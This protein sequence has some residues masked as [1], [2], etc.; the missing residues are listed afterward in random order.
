MGRRRAS[1]M[2][3]ELRQSAQKRKSAKMGKK[4]ENRE[5]QSSPYSIDMPAR[6][7]STCSL[8]YEPWF[9]HFYRALLKEKF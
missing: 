8:G 6:P 1:T 2:D 4:R 7:A 3:P 5:K 9:I